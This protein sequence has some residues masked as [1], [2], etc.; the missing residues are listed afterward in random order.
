MQID[1]RVDVY[2]L[3]VLAFEA[4]TGTRPFRAELMSIMM[5]HHLNDA[6]PA[7]G[8]AFPAAIDEVFR[9]ALAKAPEDRYA[10]PIDFASALRSAASVGSGGGL[11]RLP[12]VQRDA[13]MADA[14]QPLA[15]AVAVLE[16]AR[17]EE[18]AWTAIAELRR[19]CLHYL[20]AIAL[21]A[22]SQSH[23]RS[24][25]DA[26]I[27]DALGPLAHGTPSDREWIAIIRSLCRPFSAEPQ[28]FAVPEL[29]ALCVDTHGEDTHK[30]DEV[31]ALDERAGAETEALP[32]AIQGTGRF[33]Q[34]LSFVADY[35]LGIRRGD[36]VELLTGLRRGVRASVALDDPASAPE[37][38]MLLLDR[39]GQPRLLLSPLLKLNIAATGLPEEI[40]L[41]HG[42]G[43]RGMRQVSFPALFERYDEEAQL[44]LEANLPLSAS[45]A[46][47]ATEEL[48]PYLGLSS[49]RAE[50]ASFFYG[51]EREVESFVNRLRVQTLLAVVGPSGVGKS[52]FIHAGVL[53][54]LP[55]SWI[56]ITVR[57]G[58]APLA[59]LIARLER[60][61][62]MGLSA[63]AMAADPSLLGQCVRARARLLGQTWVFVID[64]L[65]ELFTLGVDDA[66]RDVYAE[67][68]SAHERERTYDPVRVL[69]TLRD[70]FLMRADRVPAFRSRVGAGLQLLTTP[71]RDDL[72]RILVEPARARGYAFED[73]QLPGEMVD[74]VHEQPGA[75][76]LLSFTASQL[77]ETRDRHFHRLTRR[78]YVALG[79][80]GGA[81][82]Q[83]A[84][85][86]LRALDADQ[87]RLAREAFRHLVTS[88]GTRATLTRVELRQLLGD[89]AAGETML[90]KLVQARL[91]VSQEGEGGVDRVELIHET[92]LSA[93]PRLVAWQR[94]DAEGA[95]L[96]DNLRV[97]ARQWEE[98][99][100]P[101]SLLWRDDTLAEYRLWRG[102]Y[103]GAIT[104]SEDAFAAASLRDAKRGQRFRRAT[105][106][107]IVLALSVFSAILWRANID[108]RR[109]RARSETLLA[110]SYLDEGRQLVLRGDAETALVYLKE[111][112][113][114]GARGPALDFLVTE[115]ARPLLA[116]KLLVS[117]DGQVMG[118][119]LSPDGN[120]LAT[121]DTGRKLRVWNAQTGQV[122]H[123]E[124]NNKLNWVYGAA[125]LPDAKTLL[126]SSGGFVRIDFETGR[127]LGG[128]EFAGI[129]GF[130]AVN[131]D[132]HLAAYGSRG[133]ES[134]LWDWENN[135]VVASYASRNAEIIALSEDGRRVFTAH[136]SGDGDLWEAQSGKKIA[137]LMT[138]AAAAA[139]EPHGSRLATL[140]HAEGGL[141]LFTADGKVIAS[142]PAAHAKGGEAVAWSPDGR[143]LVT[144]GDDGLVRTWRIPD[145]APE[146][147]FAG[148]TGDVERVAFLT[149]DT[150]VSLS[151]DKSVRLWSH[152]RGT[153]IG[154]LEGHTAT[155]MSLA[156]NRDRSRLVTGAW[157]ASARLWDWRAA[158]TTRSLPVRAV[159]TFDEDALTWSSMLN[160]RPPIGTRPVLSPDGKWVVTLGPDRVAWVAPLDGGAACRI[161]DGTLGVRDVFFTPDSQR[162]CA[163]SSGTIRASRPGARPTVGSKDRSPI[164]PG[165]RAPCV[166]A[167][168]ARCSL[169]ATS[170]VK[171]SCGTRA[172][173]SSYVRSPTSASGSCSS[174]SRKTIGCWS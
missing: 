159:A 19:A 146:H 125:F 92:L 169:R 142:S 49:F 131:L 77:W 58:R 11:P 14:P 130:M 57:P 64:Q 7:L 85:N 102:R 69:F 50:D 81:L 45:A 72:L 161:G 129:G 98:R 153:P 73:E 134:K 133:G 75:L 90:E 127:R 164:A 89:D 93:W 2:A 111:A 170:M 16:A 139:F 20:G 12:E 109:A 41:L 48:V 94:E 107:G 96:R 166:R 157:D 79:G 53:T 40:F 158:V 114:T 147:T 38:G 162:L 108:T 10:T 28:R 36:G 6:V 52:S 22:Y 97:A 140:A 70:D 21:A 112:Q 104:S 76:A 17:S 116:Q 106:A 66:E 145:L 120:W 63:A 150:I 1:A 151:T 42:K 43:S 54:S 103:P 91:L 80:V 74:S 84:E 33:L 27:A 9:R 174:S 86:T 113:R 18:Q 152:A 34:Q 138:N 105:L 71:N 128:V 29:V 101:R 51:R 119:A 32:I 24:H 13:W 141:S 82:A 160:A 26:R 60:D 39:D 122:V 35:A 135:R 155:P 172:R 115:A 136:W 23:Q 156:W 163:P 123:E 56:G 55:S 171:C 110:D 61:G 154:E 99:R 167:A 121:G 59:A 78:A 165:P 62:V 118:V 149:D 117:T 68:L 87:Q 8:P 44:W 25:A 144:G 46:N 47:A 3:G 168:M 126:Y 4:L 31:L 67:S 143:H 83:H 148:H 95:R 88:L 15:E 132:L 30:L 65:E 124:Q 173:A 137:A 37:E 5:R 100:R